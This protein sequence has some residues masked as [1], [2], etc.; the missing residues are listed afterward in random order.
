MGTRQADG[1]RPRIPSEPWAAPTP[2]A[3]CPL[4]DSGL[5]QPHTRV[6]PV[7]SWPLLSLGL[8][9]LP[10]WRVANPQKLTHPCALW[11]VPKTK[12][13]NVPSARLNMAPGG[14][15]HVSR[16]TVSSGS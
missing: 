6:V 3:R 5:H 15:P 10:G 7:S 14:P 2:L 4:E 12:E 13:G 9:H 11:R 16:N 8:D 1:H